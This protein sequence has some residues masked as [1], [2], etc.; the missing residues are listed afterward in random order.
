MENEE[1]QN[2]VSLRFPPPL[3]IAPRFPQSHNPDDD[4]PPSQN[5]KSKSPKGAPATQKPQPPSSGSSF[6]E[7]ML[8]PL[9]PWVDA[10]PR[11][12]LSNQ[13]PGK[14]A[15]RNGDRAQHAAPHRSVRRLDRRDRRSLLPQLLTTQSRDKRSRLSTTTSGR[16][17]GRQR[18]AQPGPPFGPGLRPFPVRVLSIRLPC[19]DHMWSKLVFS[20]TSVALSRGILATRDRID[21]GGCAKKVGKNGCGSHIKG[22]R[23]W[24]M[25]FGRDVFRRCVK[26]RTLG[27]TTFAAN[28][29]T[30]QATSGRSRARQGAGPA[31]ENRTDSRRPGARPQAHARISVLLC[32]PS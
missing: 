28:H 24:I 31:G 19:S 27:P 10:R 30:G 2:Q 8:R 22:T 16:L 18:V 11:T 4:S 21:A 1:N 12:P 26:T 20:I 23:R 3:E 5:S 6:D 14:L 9:T 17:W 32:S 15:E 29:T 7:K 13:T 25:L